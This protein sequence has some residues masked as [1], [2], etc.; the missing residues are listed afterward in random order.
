MLQNDGKVRSFS[1]LRFLNE[2][3]TDQTDSPLAPSIT[4]KSVDSNLDGYAEEVS[5]SMYFKTDNPSNIRSISLLM[6][7]DYEIQ[8]RR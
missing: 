4:T 7:F 8:V 3:F 6:G 2:E 1:S 5:L